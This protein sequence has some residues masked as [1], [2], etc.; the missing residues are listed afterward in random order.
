MVPRTLCWSRTSWPCRSSL[1]KEWRCICSPSVGPSKPPKL[2]MKCGTS[3]Q[4]SLNSFTGGDAAPVALGWGARQ[5]MPQS[6]AARWPL[7]IQRT[8]CKSWA[9]GC[10]NLWHPDTQREP[11]MDARKLQVC[12]L[13][14][15]S[16]AVHQRVQSLR[17]LP[18][19]AKGC[20]AKP[21]K[22]GM[23][24]TWQ[25]LKKGR[26]LAPNPCKRI[27]LEKG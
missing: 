14:R 18:A 8:S 27:T 9:H 5:N 2:K 10:Q 12:I 22:K 13:C 17:L 20:S 23:A 6:G 7:M 15:S 21:L 16:E 1:T 25:P 3:S 24:L 26:C 11:C 19:L 4:I